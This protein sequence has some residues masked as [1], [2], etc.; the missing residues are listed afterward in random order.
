MSR[1][2]WISLL[3][4]RGATGKDDLAGTSRLT[5]SLATTLIYLLHR[6]PHALS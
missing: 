6:S 3:A 1:L 5:L 2:N 4:T